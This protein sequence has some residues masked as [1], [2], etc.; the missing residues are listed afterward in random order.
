MVAAIHLEEIEVGGPFIGI[1]I[2]RISGGLAGFA[3]RALIDTGSSVVCISERIANQ[4]G[5]R[6]IDRANVGVVGGQTVACHV[7]GG[8]VVVESIGFD[9][10]LELYAPIHGPQRSQTV[11]LGRSFLRYC[12]MNYDGPRRSL[13]LQHG[14]HHYSLPEDWDG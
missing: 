1:T 12:I 14:S 9:E 7:Y 11:I 8:R 4:V 6:P 5:L 2:N 13:H 10:V 3:T